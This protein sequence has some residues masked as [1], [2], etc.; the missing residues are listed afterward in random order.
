MD[1]QQNRG[2][3]WIRESRGEKSYP[4]HS[5]E[6]NLT[7]EGFIIAGRIDD[8]SKDAARYRWLR[9]RLGP[10]D[11]DFPDLIVWKEKYARL[12]DYAIDTEISREEE[13]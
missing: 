13:S 3:Y 7:K 1:D 10:I 5:S 8:L 11:W 4:I 9:R 6:D 2:W 12:L